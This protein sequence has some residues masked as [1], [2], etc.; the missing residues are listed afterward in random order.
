[1]NNDIYVSV[2]VP[3]FPESVKRGE[4]LA[5][6][7]KEGDKLAKGALIL[8]LETDKVVMEVRAPESG[9]LVALN[10]P[11]TK[12]LYSGDE[13]AQIKVDSAATETSLSLTQRDET[14]I[15]E[16][17]LPKRVDSPLVE[18]EVERDVL[19]FVN[20][21]S[22]VEKGEG[23]V[24][25]TPSMSPANR[26]QIRENRLFPPENILDFPVPVPILE[27]ERREK[28]GTMRKAMLERLLSSA[29][30]AVSCT[31]F[32]EVNMGT[33]LHERA[34]RNPVLTR[35]FG[36]KVGVVSLV[37]RAVARSLVKYPILGA[38]LDYPRGEV[39]YHEKQ[40]I[41]VAIGSSRGLVMPVL[42]DVGGR[43]LLAIEREIQEKSSLAESGKL[44]L[45]DLE[46]PTF[47][48]S[49]GGVFGSLLST[50]LLPAPLSGILGIH[51]IQKRAVVVG[52]SLVVAPMCYLALTY[53]HALV[54]GKEAVSFLVDVK[55]QL[56][57]GSTLFDKGNEAES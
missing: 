21:F 37:A 15:R 53:N 44:R 9:Q 31:T 57:M 38:F 1:M 18:R 42:C 22:K 34:L 20:D 7:A 36:I 52:D 56:E 33:L 23:R 32:N 17:P 29:R 49:N 55:A 11:L 26:R 10:L 47:A 12:M 40:N 48:I 19:G 35:E 3:P 43:S 14:L 5:V 4:V 51:A 24:R 30:S 2:K 16:R 6:H 46:N 28:L 54:E 25:P 13:I 8:E 39:V 41:G 50:P 45:F 27:G